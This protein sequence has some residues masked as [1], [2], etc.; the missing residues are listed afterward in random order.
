MIRSLVVFDA[1][2]QFLDA[3]LD[4]DADLELLLKIDE[5]GSGVGHFA[6]LAHCVDVERPSFPREA[7]QVLLFSAVAAQHYDSFPRRRTR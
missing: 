7:G 2:H 4:L 3:V 6:F 1:D 5:D